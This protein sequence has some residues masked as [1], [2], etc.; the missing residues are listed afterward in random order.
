M[1]MSSVVL[2]Q[3]GS[4]KYCPS[5]C[6]KRCSAAYAGASLEMEACASSIDGSWSRSKQRLG[7]CTRSVQRHSVRTPIVTKMSWWGGETHSGTTKLICPFVWLRKG[8][9]RKFGRSVRRACEG[10]HTH[11]AE[12]KR[13]CYK[14]ES[15]GGSM[16]AWLPPLEEAKVAV[17]TAGFRWLASL[18]VTLQWTLRNHLGY[19]SLTLVMRVRRME[20]Q[21]VPRDFLVSKDPDDLMLHIELRTYVRI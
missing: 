2:K 15:R 20:K 17:E 21:S 8:R 1:G 3:L 9:S 13:V 14:G 19:Q 4:K 11:F 10:L 16:F 18:T 7:S 6:A 12:A 5:R